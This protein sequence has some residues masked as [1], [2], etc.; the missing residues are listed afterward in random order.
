MAVKWRTSLPV[1]RCP[2]DCGLCCSQL[3][4][5]T[6]AT[7]VLR[8]PRIQERAPLKMP[9]RSQPV[10]DKCWVVAGAKPCVFLEDNRCS[11]Y[12][13]RPQTC[14]IFPCGGKKCCELREQA[15]M[16]ALVPMAADGSMDDRLR[17]EFTAYEC[18]EDD[19]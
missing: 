11:I 5:E 10:V 19:Y 12:A 7:D 9:D 18:D 14:V 17:A 4:V 16:P 1:F 6:D 3:L 13:T 2:P 8:E 15:G